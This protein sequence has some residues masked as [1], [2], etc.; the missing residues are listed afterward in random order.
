MINLK[1]TSTIITA[2]AA[3]LFNSEIHNYL[4]KLNK[5]FIVKADPAT[6]TKIHT[7]WYNTATLRGL[8]CKNN[9]A[10]YITSWLFKIKRLT[11]DGSTPVCIE[12]KDM[13]TSTELSKL[14]Q[15]IV[16]A[17]MKSEGQ[18]NGPLFQSLNSQATKIQDEDGVSC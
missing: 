1:Q 3:E 6:P 16:A 7:M 12:I 17:N 4:V 2:T 11:E 10:G 14:N 13:L 18:V 8:N 9:D 5:N 15:F